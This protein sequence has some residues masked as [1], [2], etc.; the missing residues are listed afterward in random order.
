MTLCLIL[1]D[2]RSSFGVSALTALE[3]LEF[4]SP[5]L[6]ATQY[7]ADDLS[8][9]WVVQLLDDVTAPLECLAFSL[10]SGDQEAVMG[11]DWVRITTM[12]KQPKFSA[13]KRITFHVWGRPTPC[14][15]ITETVR[16][17]LT[18]LDERGLLHFDT[19]ADPEY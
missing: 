7:G 6:Y 2:L 10:W 18:E 19:M 15:V 3:V 9:E 11:D 8:F 16:K 12:L 17:Y 5:A 13:L 1:G 14:N 4:G